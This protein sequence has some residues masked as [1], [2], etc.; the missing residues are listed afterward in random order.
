S[1]SDDHLL[2]GT[3]TANA[4]TPEWTGYLFEP[5]RLSRRRQSLRGWGHDASEP[6][7]TGS[8]GAGGANGVRA[9][10]GACLAVG[11]DHVDRREDRLRGRNAAELGAAGCG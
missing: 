7:F 3:M 6:V 2:H 9:R 5:R 10:T 4:T 11:G 1:S 8:A